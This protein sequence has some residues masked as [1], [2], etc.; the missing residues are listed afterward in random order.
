MVYAGQLCVALCFMEL[1]AKYPLAGSVYNWAK[2]LGVRPL[3]WAAGW[4]LLTASVVSLAGVVLALQINLPHLWAGFQWVGDGQGPLD[5]SIN[6]VLLGGVMIFISTF[7]NAWH[8]RLLATIN[9][10]CVVIELLAAVALVVVLACHLVRGPQVFLS[11]HGYGAGLPGGYWGVFL[12]ASLAS[13]YVMYGFDTASS[14]GEEIRDPRR[15]A[16]KAILRALLASFVLGGSILA[17]AIMASPDLADPRIGS[18]NGGLQLILRSVM[19]G[20]G[21]K[22]M[23]FCVVVAVMVCALVVHAAAIR[24][25]FAMARDNALPA[26]Q[27]LARTHATR[28]TPVWAALAVGAFALLILLIN[29]G[30]QKIFTMLTSIAVVMIYLS[31]LLVTAPLLWRR[32]RGQW[33]PAELRSQGYFHLGR[34][35]LPI[36]ILAVLWGAAM[37]INLAW[38]RAEVFGE[39]WYL[40]FGAHIYIGVILGVG[41]LW[42]SLYGR[43][44][45]GVLDSQAS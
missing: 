31:Y 5:Y 14:L 6:A 21:G 19:S 20:Y 39:P 16:P 28:R 45:F 15:T 2:F 37:A 25:I 30:Q 42:Y 4:L 17:L 35:G 12:V 7:I 40:R 22:L 18:A 23:L 26:S 33:P 43:H 29:L 13:G 41:L 10:I 24:L 1:A 11:T 27:S 34:W 8:V 36:N 9:S 44:R 38:P 3:A 32:L